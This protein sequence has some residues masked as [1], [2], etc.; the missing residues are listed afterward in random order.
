M[1][2]L[3]NEILNI[4]SREN[5]SI[6]LSDLDNYPPRKIL[7]AL[8]SGLLNPDQLIR[9]HSVTAMGH[10]VARMTEKEG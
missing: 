5:I 7:G 6:S 4:L 9:W 2:R 3:K 8:F 10:V 1:K